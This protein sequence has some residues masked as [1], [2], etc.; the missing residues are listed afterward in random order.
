MENVERKGEKIQK[1]E[2][3]KNERS[4]LDEMKS[5]FHSF[6]RDIIWLKN[7]K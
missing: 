5:V 6:W 2:F 3:L 1:L 7:K 4:F